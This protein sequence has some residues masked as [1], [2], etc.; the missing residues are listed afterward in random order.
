MPDQYPF[1]AIELPS[2]R[3]TTKPRKTGLT[4]MADWGLPL[5]HQEDILELGGD[6]V[7]FAKIVTGSARLYKRGYLTDKLALYRD[8]GVRP[9]IGGQFFEY[10][11]ANQ[12]WQAVA[13]F[14]A[15][16]RNLGFETIEISD[17]CIPLSNEDRARAVALALENGLSVMGEVGS[18]N[19]SSDA[20]E[21]IGQA[22]TFF[23]AGAELVLV[24]AAELVADG[25]PK[26]EMLAELRAGLDFDRVMVELPGPWI[27]GVTLSLIQDLKKALVRELGPDVNIANVHAEDL[28]A[29][30]ALRVGLGVVGPTTRLVD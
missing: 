28:I 3:S 23:G 1:A 22:E 11:L 4:M 9:F 18:K 12:G 13:P 5:H 7:D 24:E 14:L 2:G 8:A 10:V 15:E 29:T 27:S 19:E 6:Y 20:A 21:L 26:P 17:N 30:E 16:A 25:R